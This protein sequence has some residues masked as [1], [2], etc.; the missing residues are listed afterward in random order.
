MRPFRKL[1]VI[2]LAGLLL[3]L[4]NLVYAVNLIVNPS[5]ESGTL[6]TSGNVQDWIAVGGLQI[7]TDV[8]KTEGSRAVDF[9]PG[10]AAGS[11]LSQTFATTPGTKYVLRYD[12]GIFGSGNGQ[13]VQVEITGSGT[14]ATQ[15]YARYSPNSFDVLMPT[16]ATSGIA[17]T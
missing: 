15:T 10:P 7:R 4:P 3:C 13:S 16:F 5:F 12:Y 17:F 2:A 14:L 8:G 9:N 6:S 1:P 11:T